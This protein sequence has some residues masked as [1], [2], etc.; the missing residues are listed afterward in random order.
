MSRLFKR[1]CMCGEVTEAYIG[2]EVVINGWVAKNTDDMIRK[3][4][5]SLGANDRMM[6]IN[7]ICFDAKWLISFNGSPE[8]MVVI[9]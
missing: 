1:T 8:L 9:S 3:L 4:V 6:L 7:A 2:K 5:E